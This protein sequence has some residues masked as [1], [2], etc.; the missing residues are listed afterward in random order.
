[1]NNNTN[2]LPNRLQILQLNLNKSEKAH[3]DLINSALGKQ[4]DI[5]LIQEPYLTFL[6]HIRTPNGFTSIFPTDRL[7]N[8]ESTVRSVIWINCSLPTN[9][10][11]IINIPGNNNL[12]AI[13]P[14]CHNN[15]KLTIINIYNNCT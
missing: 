2:S 8:Q 4:W 12:T 7:T 3:L 15:N 14:P 1:M 9:T 10:W 13:Q 5:I 6:G 11:K